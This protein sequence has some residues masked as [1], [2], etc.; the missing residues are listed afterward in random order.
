MTDQNIQLLCDWCS[1]PYVDFVGGELKLPDEIDLDEVMRQEL[2]EGNKHKL[3][4]PCPHCG[5]D[6]TLK[7]IIPSL[8]LGG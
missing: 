8:S 1:E 7:L 5:H 6:N 2:G 3:S 4:I